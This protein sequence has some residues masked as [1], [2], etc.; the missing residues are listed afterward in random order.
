MAVVQVEHATCAPGIFTISGTVTIEVFDSGL[1]VVSQ[2]GR[3]IG[4]WRRTRFLRRWVPYMLGTPEWT[5][6]YVVDAV[7]VPF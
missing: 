5:L 2:Q 4:S 3:I 6:P 7:E 1:A